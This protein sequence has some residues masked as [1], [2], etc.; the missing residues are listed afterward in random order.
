MRTAEN[1]FYDFERLGLQILI[2]DTPNYNG[3]DGKGVLIRQ[4]REAIAEENRKE[5]IGRLWNGRQERVRK[6]QFPGGNLPYRYRWDAKTNS[7]GA[8]RGR[9]ATT[10]VVTASWPHGTSRRDPGSC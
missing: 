4:I 6:G 7:R 2:A 1:L 10:R 8:K 9:A 5:I 3:K